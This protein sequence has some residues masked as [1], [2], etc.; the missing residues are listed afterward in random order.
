MQWQRQFWLVLG[1]W[2][3]DSTGIA[4]AQTV[5]E[6]PTGF[7]DPQ[8]HATWIAKLQSRMDVKFDTLRPMFEA[9]DVSHVA[10]GTALRDRARGFIQLRGVPQKSA[11]VRSFLVW[12]FSDGNRE[13]PDGAAVLFDGNLVFGK[14]S[15]DNT[16]PC[17]G[18]NGNHSYVADVTAYTNQSGGPNQDYEVVMPFDDKT[19]TAGENPWAASSQPGVLYEGATLFVIYRNE[20]TTGALFFF[21]P[22]GDNMFSS[23]ASY[24]LPTPAFGSGL[25]SMAG[26]DGQRGSGHDNG[27]SNE[28]T[29][30]DGN[31][32]AGPAVAASDWDGSD[33]LTLPQLW[34]THTHQ[35]KLSNNPSRIDYDAGA[36]CLV[37]VAFVLDQ[38]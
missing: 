23:S 2:L 35:V 31:Q 10:S 17:W 28:L 1:V 20:K 22:P 34:D 33:G 24:L 21:A 8:R 36:D 19:S 25:F 18:R 12:N 30:F 37:P 14:K 26:A 32:I 6:V 4:F 3:L 7:L 27:A 11:V 15:A 5:D 29:F 16:D 13:G 9:R 38:E